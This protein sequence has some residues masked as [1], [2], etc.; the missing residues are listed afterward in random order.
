[1][2]K[3]NILISLLTLMSLGVLAFFYSDL[4]DLVPKQWGVDGRINSYMGKEWLFLLT[5]LPLILLV[6][7]NIIP[8]VDPR[9]DN[10]Q[11]H[12]SSYRVIV[13][14]ISLFLLLMSMMTLAFSLGMAINVQMTVTSGVGILFIILGNLMP[15]FR[16]NYTVGIRVP[17]TLASENVWRETHRVGGIL[18]MLL[19][20]I[21]IISGFL[22]G[23][24]AM[25]T[26]LSGLVI[27]LTIS[28]VYPWKLYQKEKNGK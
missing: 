16:H 12:A 15:R 13:I 4:P 7:F 18:F 14:V 23:M 17:W 11:R 28:F 19:G 9:N 22:P 1:M 20:V 21:F 26:A 3:I 2:K 8:K 6:L 24:A 25:I 27:T 5:S 10:Y